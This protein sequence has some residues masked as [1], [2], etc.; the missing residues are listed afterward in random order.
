[1]LVS[2]RGRYIGT[3]GG[4]APMA[5]LEGGIPGMLGVGLK[6]GPRLCWPFGNGYALH[7]RPDV[8]EEHLEDVVERCS[9]DLPEGWR[10]VMEVELGSFRAQA[11]S[12][13][14]VEY[15]FDL[16]PGSGGLSLLV[17]GALSKARE[18]AAKEEDV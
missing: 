10:I 1:M 16:Y 17:D 14:G 11:V 13:E 6:D 4:V 15:C 2:Y 8:G 12:P 7:A 5:V 9:R 18:E 3:V